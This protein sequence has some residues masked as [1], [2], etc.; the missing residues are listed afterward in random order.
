MA[1]IGSDLYSP[2]AGKILSANPHAYEA[3]VVMGG[4]PPP[5]RELIEGV[6]PEDLLSKSGGSTSAGLA[7]LAGLWLWH[8]GLEE[9]HRISQS[10]SDSTGSFWHAVM[11]RREGDFS[12]S[13]Y[14]YARTT[15]H[16][17]FQTL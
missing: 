16:P 6:R 10:I 1:E 11:H 4:T 15:G 2:L 8:D 12:N 13:K 5:A 9:S 14:W 3:L 7:L 17:V